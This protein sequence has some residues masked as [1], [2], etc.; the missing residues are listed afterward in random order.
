MLSNGSIQVRVFTSNARIPIEDA[1]ITITDTNEDAIAM[2]LTNSSGQ[3]NEPVTVGVPELSLSQSPG[4]DAKPFTQVQLYAR[5]DGYE[6][7][8]VKGIQVFADT[9]T[10]QE[11][12]LIPLAEFPESFNRSETFEI[13]PQN[14]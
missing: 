2:G 4:Q 6:E 8:F 13:P 11:L 7:I 12:E 10:L 5:K 9:I 3:L 1:A 14:L